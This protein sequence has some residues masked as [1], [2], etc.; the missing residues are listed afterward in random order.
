MVEINRKVHS[1]LI[2]W[3]NSPY[4]KPLILRGARQVGKT[5]LIRQFANE[6][7]QFVE[8]NLEK[9]YHREIFDSIDDL[10]ELINAIFLSEQITGSKTPVLLFIDEVQESPKAI[11]MLRYFYEER[12]DL[13][14]IAAG[15]LLEFA[16]GDIPGFPVGRVEYLSLHPINFEEFLGMVNPKALEL[17]ERIPVPAYGH[18]LL[19]KYFHEYSVI[20]GMPEIVSRYLEN[21]N[22][23]ALSDVYKQ[24]WFSYKEDVKK[25]ARNNTDKKIIRHVID[26]APK[27][28]DRI[29]FEGF[30]RSNYRSREVGEAMRALDLAQVVQLIY[31]TTSL[32]PPLLA[33]LKK[34]P[35]L[36]FLDTGLLSQILSLQREMIGIKDLNGFYKGKII[37]Q[38][39]SQ[40]LISLQ[41]DPS[42]RPHFWVREKKESSAEVDLVYHYEQYVI[43]IEIKS[44]E[45]GRLRSLHQ[46]IDRCPHHYGIRLLANYFSVEN[47]KTISGKEYWLMNLPYYLATRIPEYIKWF[48]TNHS[49]QEPKQ[50]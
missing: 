24:L 46:F 19:L 32:E 31:P 48:V 45:Q 26:S 37:Q 17:L 49:I 10:S 35:R 29:K 7:P 16:L 1:D 12:P 43:P 42:Y 20:G 34:R 40:Q 3:K 41:H 11:S 22:I 4:R 38:L 21:Q 27:E 36:Q 2:K 33:D 28:T 18:D 14:V 13:H 25:Y 47:V 5:S 30:G 8:L 15:S 50:P 6:Y 44:G 9:K 39:V 23:A